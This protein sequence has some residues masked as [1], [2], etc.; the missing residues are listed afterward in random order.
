MAMV[1]IT[2]SESDRAMYPKDDATPPFVQR[3][4]FRVL[5]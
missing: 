2:L 4:I 1:R 3:L 5:S